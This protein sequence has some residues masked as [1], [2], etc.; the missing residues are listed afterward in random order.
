MVRTPPGVPLIA[1]FVGSWT[2]QES[3]DW[4]GVIDPA[5]FVCHLYP[6]DE[7]IQDRPH[8]VLIAAVQ[9]L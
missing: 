1:T 3:V 4:H 7:E 9:I 5:R 6:K 8:F 2:G